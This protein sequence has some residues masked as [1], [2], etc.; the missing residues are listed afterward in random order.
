MLSRQLLLQ[1][2]GFPVD[3]FR[4]ATADDLPTLVRIH[5]IAYSQS[6]FTA[7]LPDDVLARYYG[8]F[9]DGG[10]EI[11]L[12][13]DNAADNQPEA[14]S[15][16]NVQGFAVFGSGIPKKIARFKTECFRDIFI[17]SLRHPW[18]AA[19]KTAGAILSRLS[20]RPAHPPAEFLLLSIA[21]A[22]PRRGVGRRLLGAML[23]VS[24][25]SGNE[26]AGLYVNA[27]NI[28]AINAYFAAGFVIVDFQSGQFYMEK[29]L[30]HP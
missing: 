9:L 21:V 6:H 20:R 3:E 8:Y 17:A 14:P 18:I 24:E 15:F 30:G 22:V 11:Y 2:K 12:A 19:R 5:K 23:A 7:L 25:R 27:D 26:I 29:T 1:P 28:S 4:R 16:E 10:S 13:L